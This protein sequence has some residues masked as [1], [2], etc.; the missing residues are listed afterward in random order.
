MKKFREFLEAL[1]TQGGHI[2]VCVGLILLGSGL[3]RAGITKAEDI[4]LGA[5]GAVLLAMKG[6]GKHV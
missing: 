2:V 6:N 1:D 4:I 3:F 5:F